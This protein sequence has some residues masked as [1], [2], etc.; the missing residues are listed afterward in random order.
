MFGQ[1][2]A[3]PEEAQRAEINLIKRSILERFPQFDPDR[4]YLTPGDV[5]Y[6][7]K[8]D[9]T[10]QEFIRLCSQGPEKPPRKHI[11]LIVP[12]SN[13]KP[14]DESTPDKSLKNIYIALKNL[15]AREKVY[16]YILSPM[17]GLIP[18][19][20]IPRTPNVEFSGLYSYQVRRRSL[21]WDQNAFKE[22]LDL[23]AEV[24]GRY[25]VERL[26]DHKD[27]YVI[28]KKNSLEER[29]FARIMELHSLPIHFKYIKRPLSS[30]YLEAREIIKGILEESER[31]LE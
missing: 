26:L 16:L 6:A 3:L 31:S 11:G 23:T 14:L 4:I 9:E 25:L 2:E 5:L 24:V 15:K 29:I 12:D 20:Y 22:V 21:P 18:E 10:V 28:L 19:D 7:L 1:K 8:N 30:S 27:W 17:L 13:Y